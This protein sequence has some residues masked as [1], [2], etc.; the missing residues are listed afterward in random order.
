MSITRALAELKL[1][2]RRIEKKI[3]EGDYVYFLSKKYKNQL[4]NEQLISNSKSTF[5]S[6]TD[7]IE[8]RK[9]IKRQVCGH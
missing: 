7:L 6:I 8:R 9:R 1:L 3:S 2:D 5:Q 4:S